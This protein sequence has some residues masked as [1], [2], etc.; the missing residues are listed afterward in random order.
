MVTDEGL[1]EPASR[2][3]EIGALREASVAFPDAELLVVA[4]ALP[5]GVGELGVQTLTLGR[6][7]VDGG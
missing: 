6:F 1:L 7:L 3:R 4:G 2:E 5:S